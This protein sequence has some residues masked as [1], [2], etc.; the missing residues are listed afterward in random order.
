MRKT[1]AIIILI[2]LVVSVVPLY[3]FAEENS[4]K[5]PQHQSNP[6][7]KFFKGLG[8]VVADI[9]TLGQAKACQ[10]MEEENK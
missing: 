2:A 6:V 3:S 8:C 7:G 1:I 9:A 10:K 4:P 5:P